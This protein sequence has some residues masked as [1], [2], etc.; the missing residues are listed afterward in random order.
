MEFSK[1]GVKLFVILYSHLKSCRDLDS[2]YVTGRVLQASCWRVS[3]LVNGA[4]VICDADS[5]VNTVLCPHLCCVSTVMSHQDQSLIVPGLAKRE[6]P[7]VFL[8]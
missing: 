8:A 5:W 7:T 3:V 6:T 2:D 1:F 4:P